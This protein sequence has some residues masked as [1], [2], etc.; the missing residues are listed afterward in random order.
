MLRRFPGRPPALDLG[1][2][3]PFLPD[4]PNGFLKHLSNQVPVLPQALTGF[5]GALLTQ[6]RKALMRWRLSTCLA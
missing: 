4:N 3:Y 5:V 2:S 6:I 1:P